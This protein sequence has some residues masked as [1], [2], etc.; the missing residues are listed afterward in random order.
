MS[1]TDG[2]GTGC[3]VQQTLDVRTCDCTM[4]EHVDLRDGRHVIGITRADAQLLCMGWPLAQ[5]RGVTEDEYRNA[6]NRVMGVLQLV[7][8]GQKDGD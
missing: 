2:H 8:V 5:Q 7:G 6:V 4:N 1:V 3:A